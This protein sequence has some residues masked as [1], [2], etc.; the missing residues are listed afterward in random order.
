MANDVVM[1]YHA[2]GDPS[3]V[4]SVQY[5]THQVCSEQIERWQR[6]EGSDVYEVGRFSSR[7]E[8]EQFTRTHGYQVRGW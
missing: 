6:N 7:Q 3:N 4:V 8:A 1:L 2:C 5:G